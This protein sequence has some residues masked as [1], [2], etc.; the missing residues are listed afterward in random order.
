MGPT[1]E[2]NTVEVIFTIIGLSFWL[3]FPIGMFF[4][5]SH[6]D[7]NTD[8]IIRLQHHEYHSEPITETDVPVFKQHFDWHHPILY[9]RHWLHQP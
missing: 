3:L 5:V 6:V 8:Q 2:G 7:K 9:F 4:S 1:I